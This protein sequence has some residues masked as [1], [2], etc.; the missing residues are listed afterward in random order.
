MSAADPSQSKWKRKLAIAGLT[1]VATL[2][3]GEIGLRV[4]R[5]IKNDPYSSARATARLDELMNEVRGLQF[6]PDA[7]KAGPGS[8]GLI[9]NPYQGFQIA[10][11][12][13][14]GGKWQTYFQGEEARGNYDVLI[15]GGSVAAHFSN[16]SE[17]YLLPALQKDPRLSN[18]SFKFHSV[19]CPAHKQPQHAMGL[20]WLFSAGWEPDAVILIDGYNEIAI[21]TENATI[22]VNPAYPNWAEMQMR[23][24]TAMTDPR[25]Y[26]IKARV[27]MAQAEAEDLNQQLR[28]WPVTATAITG[29]WAVR[30]LGRAVGRAREWRRHLRSHEEEELKKGRSLPISGPPFDKAPEKVLQLAL[31]AWREGSLSMQ[32]MC[33]VRGVQF[34]HVLQPAACDVGSKPLTEDEIATAGQSTAWGVSIAAGY[35]HLREVGQE[36]ARAGV[37]YFDASRAFAD[38]PETIYSDGCHFGDVGSAIMSRLIAEAFLRY[39]R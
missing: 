7:A 36:L 30:V 37:N 16:Y 4:H 24:G 9:L 2:L 27:L 13:Q 10:W 21:A 23:L 26:D 31:E 15:M 33:R 35:P 3:T 29:T 38:H 39:W 12:A 20:Q 6:V 8:L 14:S 32:A 25:A 18:R 1:A 11:L 28:A 22:G 34:L 19:A 17:R 5:W